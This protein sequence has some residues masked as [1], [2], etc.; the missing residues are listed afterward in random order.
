MRASPLCEGTVCPLLKKSQRNPFYGFPLEIVYFCLFIRR[1]GCGLTAPTI[2]FAA[3]EGVGLESY[4]QLAAETEAL[5]E[6]LV[7]PT[8]GSDPVDPVLAAA[9]RLVARLPKALRG[10]SSAPEVALRPERDLRGI[11]LRRG[12]T[13]LATGL[14]RAAWGKLRAAARVGGHRLTGVR[15]ALAVHSRYWT[16]RTAR[17]FRAWSGDGPKAGKVRGS[18][19]GGLDGT[20][21]CL[22]L[23][24]WQLVYLPLL[25]F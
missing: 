24:C 22:V 20:E 3:M 21:R 18:E 10:Q 1:C 7:S 11:V 15:A 13:L 5:L 6:D 14:Q 25:A 9:D 23:G 19:A 17:A 12:L 8:W 4:R 2:I 16:R